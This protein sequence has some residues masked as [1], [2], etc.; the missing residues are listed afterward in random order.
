MTMCSRQLR[1]R[2][3]C[4]SKKPVPERQPGRRHQFGSVLI[5]PFDDVIR[6]KKEREAPKPG[7]GREQIRKERQKPEQEVPEPPPGPHEVP[8]G[9][10]IIEL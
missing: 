10:E 7:D 4:K 6:E 5:V 8:R 3:L 9:V 2:A 1:R